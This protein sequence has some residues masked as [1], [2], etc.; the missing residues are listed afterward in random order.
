MNLFK[1]HK[2]TKI[3][4]SWNSSLS[5]TRNQIRLESFRHKL[6]LKM[7]RI[8]HKIHFNRSKT[9]HL[10][11]ISMRAN[12]SNRL[13]SNPQSKT[14]VAHENKVNSWITE[15]Y[16]DLLICL[17]RRAWDLAFQKHMKAYQH[18]LICH[19]VRHFHLHKLIRVNLD[20][21]LYVLVRLR[22]LLVSRYR[23]IVRFHS[24]SL[25]SR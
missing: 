13:S 19:L 5:K 7:F 15:P 12:R 16:R 21:D 3:K 10:L 6:Q 25:F 20:L 8:R 4:W 23:K 1:R 18:R 9:S 2:W 11:K 22:H 24:E 14:A 17:I